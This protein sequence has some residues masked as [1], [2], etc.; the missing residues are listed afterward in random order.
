MLEYVTTH[1]DRDAVFSDWLID[2]ASRANTDHGRLYVRVT[3]DA[4]TTIS[5]Y[6]DSA[7]TQLVAEGTLDGDD[8]GEVTLTEENGSG[9]SGGVHV[10]FAGAQD[11]TIDAFYADD[12]DVTALRKDVA[13]FLTGGEFAGRPGFADPLARAKRVVDALLNARMRPGWRAD[14]LQP[15]ADVTA[16][17][18]LFFIYDYLTSRTDDAAA[19]RASH[20]RQ[21]ARAALPQIQLSINGCVVRP[22][23]PR[24]E[25]A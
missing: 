22:F 3:Q 6:Q 17:F 11:A 4:D 5:L 24:V 23:T 19:Q 18:A 1:D 25:R 2:G 20:W 9:L 7:H 12:A 8:T 21:E 16:R 14:D 10:N 15:L 13:G